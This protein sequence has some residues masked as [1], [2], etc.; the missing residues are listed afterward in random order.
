MVHCVYIAPMPAHTALSPNANFGLSDG[1]CSSRNLFISVVCRTQWLP[2]Q[3]SRG[4][5]TTSLRSLSVYS[6]MDSQ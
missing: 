1:S 5:L 4:V 6:A 2:F 3:W